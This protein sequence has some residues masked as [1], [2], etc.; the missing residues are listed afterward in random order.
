MDRNDA[1]AEPQLDPVLGVVYG[2]TPIH[3]RPDTGSQCAYPPGDG[4]SL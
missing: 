4:P 2:V 1:S 3:L